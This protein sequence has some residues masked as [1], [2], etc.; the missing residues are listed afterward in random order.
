MTRLDDYW[1]TTKRAREADELW[2]AHNQRRDGRSGRPLIEGIY[3][4]HLV[5]GPGTHPV[6][7]GTSALGQTYLTAIAGLLAEVS[8]PRLDLAYRRSGPLAPP[9]FEAYG[10]DFDWS[11]ALFPS[12]PDWPKWGKNRGSGQV[13][14]RDF[15]L[16][17][18]PGDTPA[19]DASEAVQEAIGDWWGLAKA[20]IEILT[21]Q[22]LEG[23]D[24]FHWSR[25]S[26]HLL[27]RDHADG[28]W[29]LKM[30]RSSLR[31][32]WRPNMG[33]GVTGHLSSAFHAAGCNHAPPLEWQLLR[34]ALR[35]FEV[36]QYRRVLMEA[37]IAAEVALTEYLTRARRMPKQDKPTLGTLVAAE[38][39]AGEASILPRGFRESVL[40]ARN[41]V[42]HHRQ[43]PTDDDAML[44]FEL[45]VDLLEKASPRDR[46]AEPYG[47][48]L[49]EDPP[50]DTR[51]ETDR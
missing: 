18:D 50:I 13:T 2:R 39:A 45:T 44:A 35:A 16:A 38:E 11:G 15:R 47:L 37:G 21:S 12:E 24:R 33:F 19:K 14:I 46:L 22:D 1:Y 8:M 10:E 17:V 29:N 34:E 4:P 20:W 40:T 36:G 43:F 42:I 49:R 30:G 23:A 6:N 31:H 48:I 25:G 3:H 9:K 41:Q 28:D 5:D 27:Y 32:S 7:A 26:L 51:P